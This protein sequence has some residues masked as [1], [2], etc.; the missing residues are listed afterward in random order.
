M[1]CEEVD[2]L[3]HG[4]LDEELDIKTGIEIGE[5]IEQ[6]ERC[7]NNLDAF[8]SQSR[9]MKSDELIYHPSNN[10][11]REFILPS[12]RSDDHGM[13]PPNQPGGS[14]L[15]RCLSQLYLQLSGRS[16]LRLVVSPDMRIWS[17][18]R[19]WIVTCERFCRDIS[20]MFFRATSIR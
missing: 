12:V 16:C 1:N 14:L 8:K 2:L 9:A 13:R 7:A 17:R 6:C 5:H 3:I 4:Y 18:L 19:S 15:S 10:F 20:P 11:A